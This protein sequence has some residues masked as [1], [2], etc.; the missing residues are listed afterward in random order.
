MWK[1]RSRPSV[2][3][4][5]SNRMAA[6]TAGDSGERIVVTGWVQGVGF[7]WTAARLARALGIS[8]TVRNRPDGAVEIRAFGEPA[9][10]ERFREALRRDTPGRVDALRA[11]A[12]SPAEN[13]ELGDDFRIVG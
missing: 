6:G 4:G 10:R 13:E 11:S 5:D 3:P 8:G 7:R 2:D 1:R 9:A 12:L